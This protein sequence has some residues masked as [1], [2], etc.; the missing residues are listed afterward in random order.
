MPIGK[1]RSVPTARRHWPTSAP[2]PR[3]AGMQESQTCPSI[4]AAR[5]GAAAAAC[6]L[7]RI[8][9]C[10]QGAA[11]TSRSDLVGQEFFRNPA[12]TVERLRAC[13]PVVEIR[14][15]IVGKVWATTTYELA[16]RVLKDSETF[17]M[18]SDG[19]IAGVRWW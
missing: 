7:W 19:T 11:M 8:A 1:F 15:P 9:M 5:H 17:T 4:D 18:R 12:A 16:A 14:L 3:A 13:G 6:H 10:G 2:E